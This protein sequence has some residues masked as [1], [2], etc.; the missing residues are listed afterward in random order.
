MKDTER[1]RYETFLRVREFGASREAEFPQTTLAGELFAGLNGII[2]EIDGHTAAQASGQSASMESTGSKSAAR[3]ELR[4]DLEAISRTARVMARTIPGL[5]NKFRAPR[6]ISDQALLA[7]ARAFAAD[8]LPLKAEFTRRGL[9]DDFLD[10]LAADIEAFEEAVN[11]Q[12]QKREAQVAATAAL[13]DAIERGVS[14]VRE[15]DAIMRNK[16][17][18]DHASLAAWLSASH[19]ERPPRRAARSTS[20]PD[21]QPPAPAS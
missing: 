4:R 3:D 13:D 11:Q 1:L 15:L 6:S 9:P 14:I 21:A 8:A 10:D 16:L 18:T 7:M 2:A 17:A 12:I 5:E 20:P 19:I